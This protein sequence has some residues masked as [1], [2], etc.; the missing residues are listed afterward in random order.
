M[1]TVILSKERFRQHT[2]LLFPLTL[3]CQVRR[4]FYQILAF[5]KKR[6]LRQETERVR[7]SQRT[8]L[9]LHQKNEKADRR[10]T[11]VESKIGRIPLHIGGIFAKELKP[12]ERILTEAFMDVAARI[13]V[14]LS[15]RDSVATLNRLLRR[16]DSDTV[17]L[18]TLSNSMLRIGEE[19]SQ[20]LSTSNRESASNVWF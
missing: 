5:L 8:F 19:I 16:N 18:R 20:T 7:K 9:N 2:D 10:L 13:C 1:R 12:K 17:K 15:F 3:I 11:T 14:N 4:D 6:F